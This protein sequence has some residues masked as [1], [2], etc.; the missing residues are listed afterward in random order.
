MV[1]G[2]TTGGQARIGAELR[3]SDE[4]Q[5]RASG[6]PT[7]PQCPQRVAGRHPIGVD[8][9]RASR[10]DGGTISGRVSE[11]EQDDIDS[12]VARLQGDPAQLGL[13]VIQS[14]LRFHV[15]RISD[16]LER[17]DHGVPGAKIAVDR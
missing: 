2:C 7:R 6:V 3:A 15:E 17:A 14:R 11:N 12:R 16:R 9:R 13:D 4:D 10:V 5:C 8:H 1:M